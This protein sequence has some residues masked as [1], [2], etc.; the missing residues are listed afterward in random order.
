MDWFMSPA[1]DAYI[2]LPGILEQKELSNRCIEPY[3]PAYKNNFS[4]QLNV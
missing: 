1:H 3:T 2:P 4:N